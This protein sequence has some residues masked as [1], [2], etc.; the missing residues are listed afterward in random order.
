[1]AKFPITRYSLLDEYYSNYNWQLFFSSWSRHAAAAAGSSAAATTSAPNTTHLEDGG[2]AVPAASRVS[3]TTNR[4]M[5]GDAL[6]G[7]EILNVTSISRQW[8]H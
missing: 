5:R 7:I 1:M 6:T 3:P 4:P 8:E 2:A